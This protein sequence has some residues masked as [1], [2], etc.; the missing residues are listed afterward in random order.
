MNVVRKRGV[1]YGIIAVMLMAP[2]G[3]SGAKAVDKAGG[4]APY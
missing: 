1:S 4:T 2:L 3:C